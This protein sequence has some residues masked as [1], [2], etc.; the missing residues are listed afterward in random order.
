[1]PIFTAWKLTLPKL[2]WTMTV[3]ERESLQNKSD[4]DDDDDRELKPLAIF[5][6]RLDWMACIHHLVW[7]W[8]CIAHSLPS[9]SCAWP[10]CFCKFRFSHSHTHSMNFNTIFQLRHCTIFLSMQFTSLCSFLL[11]TL[12]LIPFPSL[13]RS[14]TNTPQPHGTN[15]NGL[16]GLC[17]GVYVSNEN[18]DQII[19]SM[20]LIVS[21]NV[22]FSYS[23][24]N[25]YSYEPFA[26]ITWMWIY[27]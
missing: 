17:C 20:W 3:C 11:V 8:R 24:D 5:F 14:R 1:M 19:W 25:S 18:L 2:K 10:C 23:N 4:D 12:S 15:W 21:I 9:S 7:R 6:V 22:R 27:T 26:G 16:I 13:S